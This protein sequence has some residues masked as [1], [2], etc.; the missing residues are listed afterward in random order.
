M[1]KQTCLAVHGLR[2][3][4]R[5]A[6]KI[7]LAS[8]LLYVPVSFQFVSS[9]DAWV[10]H[11]HQPNFFVRTLQKF[12]LALQKIKHFPIGCPDRALNPVWHKNTSALYCKPHCSKTCFVS[13]RFQMLLFLGSSNDLESPNP[14]YF[15]TFVMMAFHDLSAWVSPPEKFLSGLPELHGVDACTCT[16]LYPSCCWIST[17]ALTLENISGD[18][19]FLTIPKYGIRATL[20][21]SRRAEFEPQQTSMKAKSWLRSTLSFIMTSRIPCRSLVGTSGSSKPKLA[22]C[23]R[24]ALVGKHFVNKSATLSVPA[25]CSKINS[26]AATLALSHS[27]RIS[28][29]LLLLGMS[30]PTNSCKADELSDSSRMCGTSCTCISPKPR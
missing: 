25:L 16:H 29:R 4:A 8:S 11:S 13:G 5:T 12:A 18:S 3:P 21:A 14:R 19:M 23:R 15:E 24:N 9:R 27:I 22:R 30:W 28:M 17:H 7:A 26:L 10:S 6:I 1:Q 2:L 20:Q